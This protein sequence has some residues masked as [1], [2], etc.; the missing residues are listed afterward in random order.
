MYPIDLVNFPFR[1]H[2]HII[3]RIDEYLHLYMPEVYHHLVASGKFHL[4]EQPDFEISGFPLLLEIDWIVSNRSKHIDVHYH[5]IKENIITKN[6]TLEYK[7]TQEILADCWRECFGQMA[8]QESL[9]GFV[10]EG[11]LKV[12]LTTKGDPNGNKETMAVIH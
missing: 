6:I 4:I 1:C 12:N 7:K 5:F 10:W 9:D 2:N 3:W 8:C 11:V